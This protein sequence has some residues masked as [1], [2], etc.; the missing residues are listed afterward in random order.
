MYFEGFDFVFHENIIKM[1]YLFSHKHRMKKC[2][3]T[4]YGQENF[5]KFF[6]NSSQANYTPLNAY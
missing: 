1:F 5:L 4:F 2:I 3:N 6:D